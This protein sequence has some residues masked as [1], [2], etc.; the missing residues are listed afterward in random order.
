MA[1]PKSETP[2]ISYHLSGQAIVKID[3]VT[4]YLGR[5]GSAEAFSRYAVLLRE[6]QANGLKLPE[7]ITPESIRKLAVESDSLPVTVNQSEEPIRVQHVT[8]AYKSHVTK[9]YE[10]SISERNRLLRM[11]R[12]VDAEAKSIEGD[13]FGPRIL[14]KMRNDWIA[15]GKSRQYC[16]RLTN[17]VVRMFKWAVSQELVDVATHHRLKTVEPLRIGET[18][19]EETKP[20][21]PANLKHVRETAKYLPPQLRAVIRIQVATGARPSEILMMRPAE[22]DRSGPEWIYR[23]AKHKNAK[24]GMSRAIP[25]VGDAKEALIDYLNRDP[26]SFCFSPKEAVEWWNAQKRA[27]RKT[28]VQPSQRD[29]SNPNAAKVPGDHYDKHSYRRAVERA[30]AKA[31]VPYWHPYQLRHLAGTMVRDALGPEHAQAFLGH[32]NIQMTEHYAKISERKA[33]EAAKAAPTLGG[34]E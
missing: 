17:S 4:F 13:K 10:A 26:E 31:G 12:I 3:G 32:A 30:C 2:A 11:C 15:A 25:I 16:N 23:P 22:I 29:R 27:A 1:R 5:H 21:V 9:R 14:Q 28:K 24:R 19:A 8:E 6:Y 20:I 18:D 7:S 33:I 34:A